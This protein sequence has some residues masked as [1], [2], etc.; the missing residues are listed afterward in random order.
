[1]ELKYLAIF[2]CVLLL[3]FISAFKLSYSTFIYERT[4]SANDI[5]LNA[6]RTTG[7]PRT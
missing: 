3:V 5:T 4:N 7:E 2:S 1:M 6:R